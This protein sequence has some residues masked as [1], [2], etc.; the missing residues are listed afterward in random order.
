MNIGI[1]A[2]H[3]SSSELDQRSRRIVGYLLALLIVLSFLAGTNVHA[4]QESKPV[5]RVGFPIQSGMSYRNERGDYAG[6]LVDYL[7]Q[8]ELFTDW[9]IE[10]VQVEGDLDTQLSTL[11]YMLLDGEIDIMGTMNRNARLEEMF[12]YPNYSYGTTYTTLAVLEDDLRWVEE[13]FTNWNGIRI[14]TYPGYASKLQEVAH[15]AAVNNFSYQTVECD[16]YEEMLEAVRNGEADA[17]IQV[18]VSMKEDLRSIGRFSPMPYYFAVHKEDT[19]LLQ[20]MNAAMRSL[21]RSQPNLQNELY[22]LYFRHT[23]SFQLSAEHQAY[24]QSLGPLNVLFFSGD[25]PYQ[26]RKGG[27]LK[28]FAVEYWDSFARSAGLQ[29]NPVVADTYEEA[30]EL[31][32]R[33][34]VDLVACVPT[35]STLSA[36][37]DVQFTLPYLNSF[38]V[39]ACSNPEPHK[40]RSDLR[41]WIN[42]EAALDQLQKTE[43][44]GVQL[45]YYSLTYYLR[46]EGVYD[47]VNV[48]WSNT[49]SFSYVFGVTGNVPAEFVTILNQYT[50]AFSNEEKQALLY[51]YSG[52]EVEYTL[53]EWMTAH[54]QVLLIG[55]VALLALVALAW[56]ALHS[57]HNA[58]K[59]LQA[60][61]RLGHLAMY[62]ELTGAY[63]ESYFRKLVQ[64]RCDRKENDVLVAFNIR[65]FRY[66]NDTYGTKR[67]NDLLCGIIAVLRPWMHEGELACRPAADLFYLLLKETDTASL[68]GRIAD[69]SRNI[70]TMASSTLEGLP[71]T[72]YCGAVFVADSHAPYH[73][74]ANMSYMMAALAHAKKINCAVVYV[75]DEAL[76]Q[77]EQLRYYIETHMQP[78]LEQEEYQL[79]LQ[80]K[81][82]LQT[83]RVDGAEALVRWQS[84]ERGMIYPDQFIPLFEENGFC[85]RLDLYMVEQVCKTLRQ[86]M[87]CGL[88]PVG[89]AVNQ[90]KALFVKEDYVECLLAITGKYRIAPQSI[91]LEIM[92]GLAFENLSALNHTIQRLN[93]EGFQV[94][95]DD[96]GSGYSSLNTLGRLAINELKLDRG[97]LMDAVNDPK[98]AQSEVLAAILVLAKKLGIKTVAEGVETKKSEDMIRAMSCDY[99][100][101]YYYSKPIPAEDFREKFCVM[102]RNGGG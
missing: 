78:A 83:G 99:G 29:Y 86:W 18:D 12:L 89:I 51:H 101:G 97:F 67:A 13:D 31:V 34:Q 60:E 55:C 44:Y 42:T 61:R 26:Y 23:E 84:K 2:G 20:Q 28:G 54:R 46:K 50:N 56:F 3:A 48:D 80:P 35:N 75:F 49:K 21:S 52:D 19:A 14:A 40:Q 90:T 17:A 93:R 62:D 16:S 47:H 66:I 45:D 70:S 87:D 71:L 72:I 32:E 25:A 73:V 58:D 102:R 43:D 7:H 53:G 74:S 64:E 82:N 69:M 27:E 77:T 79:Y 22:D 33:G 91:T 76:Y 4:S 81:M 96:F 1:N 10:Y 98:G 95:M 8:L 37:N 41:F 15:Y 85:Q 65:G 92:E 63:N 94:S 36:L 39:S 100:Q 59:A 5:V 6:C 57:R 24:L 9:E 68:G 30:V 38:S 88:A 11:M